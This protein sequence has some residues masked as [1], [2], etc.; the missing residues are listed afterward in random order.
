[1]FQNDI[2]WFLF[3]YLLYSYSCFCSILFFQPSR[4]SFYEPKTV[5]A[6]IRQLHIQRQVGVFGSITVHW[7]V[8]F[9]ICG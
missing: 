5:G 9:F 2:F 7:R 1:M 8:S 3:Y 6:T 4:V